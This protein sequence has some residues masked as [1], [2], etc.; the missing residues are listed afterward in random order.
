MFYEVF[1]VSYARQKYFV[2][3]RERCWLAVETLVATNLSGGL[4]ENRLIRF[5]KLQ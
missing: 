5:L 1:L 3:Q 2:R 4:R